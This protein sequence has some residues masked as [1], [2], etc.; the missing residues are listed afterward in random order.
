M[1]AKLIKNAGLSLVIPDTNEME[2]DFLTLKDNLKQRWYELFK[3][4]KLAKFSWKAFKK[5]GDDIF[6]DLSLDFPNIVNYG[7]I[8]PFGSQ[9]SGSSAR[10]WIY[11]HTT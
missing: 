9:A 3:S 7:A 10:S 8:P 1:A 6:I 4:W 11:V 2:K 5:D